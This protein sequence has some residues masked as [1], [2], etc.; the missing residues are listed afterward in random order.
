MRKRMKARESEG[1]N[2]YWFN[3][4]HVLLLTTVSDDGKIRQ[5]ISMGSKRFITDC[6]FP[7]KPSA[8]LHDVW[9][10]ERKTRFIV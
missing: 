7:I 8:L 4:A 3:E 2:R 10:D 5:D 1:K 6:R 9:E